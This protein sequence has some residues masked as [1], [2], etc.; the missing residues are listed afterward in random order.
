MRIGSGSIGSASAASTSSPGLVDVEALQPHPHEALIEGLDDVGQ[1]LAADG[2]VLLHLVPQAVGTESDGLHGLDASGIQRPAVGG[3]QP[4]QA[5]DVPGA[6]AFDGH[7]A[8]GGDMLLERDQARAKEVERVGL[9]PLA[10]D[11]RVLFVLDL[12][13]TRLGAL[14]LRVAQRSEERMVAVSGEI[15]RTWC[16]A[17]LRSTSPS[18]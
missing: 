18:S 3:K 16:S 6:E 14:E 2:V 13:G 9:G 15:R 4:G 8:L 17:I 1:E 10:E 7:D 12:A 11:E 5:E